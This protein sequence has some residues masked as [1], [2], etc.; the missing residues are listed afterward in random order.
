[1]EPIEH[2]G[3]RLLS[4]LDCEWVGGIVSASKAMRHSWKNLRIVWNLKQEKSYEALTN[5]FFFALKNITNSSCLTARN[6]EPHFSS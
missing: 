4:C 3:K 1:V 6:L 5:S 2:Q